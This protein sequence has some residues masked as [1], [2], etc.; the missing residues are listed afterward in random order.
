MPTRAGLLLI[1]IVLAPLHADGLSLVF[2][3]VGPPD[4]QRAYRQSS[5]GFYLRDEHWKDGFWAAAHGNG[6]ATLP[7]VLALAL[8]ERALEVGAHWTAR[9][10]VPGN[11]GLELGGDVE[12]VA[13]VG[14]PGER[15]ATLKGRWQLVSQRST[16]SATVRYR[17]YDLRYDAEYGER[18]GVVVRAS[19]RLE[20]TLESPS[21]SGGGVPYKPPPEEAKV[22]LIPPSPVGDPVYAPV[23]QPAIEAAIDAGTKFLLTRQL[24]DGGWTTDNGTSSQ[25]GITA[26]VIL[27]VAEAGVAPDD[28][29]ITKAI[30]ALVA[31]R[32]EMLG[33]TRSTYACGLACMA[34]EA[35]SRRRAEPRVKGA[36]NS[37][38]KG[39]HT[40]TG[41][42]RELV[43][44]AARQL[45][46]TQQGGCWTYGVPAAPG[47]GGAAPHDNSN[48]QYAMLGLRA[49]S[50]CGV[51]VPPAVW[52]AALAHWVAAQEA[53]P[54]TGLAISGQDGTPRGWGY[55]TGEAPY[56]S[57][58]CA[59]LA[60][61]LI[62]REQL[63]LSHNLGKAQ[64]AAVEVAV[65]DGLRWINRHFHPEQPRGVPPPAPP[66]IAIPAGKKPA[67]G[68]FLYG[69]ERAC[70]F[71]ELA[72]LNERD[73][74]QQGARVLLDAQESAG[75]FVGGNGDA[76]NTAF[77]LLFL[78]RATVPLVVITGGSKD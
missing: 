54:A 50:Q 61:V 53:A 48:T 26:L 5:S 46:G 14:D 32:A 66:W 21:A 16:D 37:S 1:A 69:A 27:A 51:R 73:W 47:A 11:L 28:P 74:Y 60:C 34:L 49:A 24:P 62:A 56:P 30:A 12:L 44:V 15:T 55:T 77:A 75:P 4:A 70:V 35:A 45:I 20:Q 7:A 71:G 52:Q 31:M 40:L 17:Q 2:K 42:E 59:G 3:P 78:K 36:R 76:S 58:T 43:G 6:L 8:P 68:Y 10:S 39:A 33:D 38:A 64:K 57:M 63:A 19:Y 23:E 9:Y 13:V 18:D 41:R 25:P 72:T 29:A 67:D 65:R 22:E